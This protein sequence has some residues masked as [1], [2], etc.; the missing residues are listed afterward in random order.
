MAQVEIRRHGV[1]TY[2]N[3]GGETW[4]EVCDK[5]LKNQSKDGFDYDYV[6]SHKDSI[7]PF[8]ARHKTNFRWYKVRDDNLPAPVNDHRGILT[9]VLTNN[10]IDKDIHIRFYYYVDEKEKY[11]E[12]QDINHTFVCNTI[13]S[14]NL[15][16]KRLYYTE[17]YCHVPSSSSCY[18]QG[19]KN[20][21][22]SYHKRQQRR[23]KRR[24]QKSKRRQRK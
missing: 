24:Q 20:K 19:G 21:H 15:H 6:F 4:E 5:C 8:A 12:I 17:T 3:H 23:S 11:T 14:N 18:I 13:Q 7:K 22:K 9:Y 1:L 10:N 16:K 2:Y